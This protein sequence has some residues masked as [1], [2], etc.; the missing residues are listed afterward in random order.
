MKDKTKTKKFKKWFLI[1]AIPVILIL[2]GLIAKRILFPPFTPIPVTGTLPV[3]QETVTW[4]DDSR[5]ETFTTD[6]S[7]RWLS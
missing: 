3:A 7:N 4:T 6:G 5:I 2:I 1:P